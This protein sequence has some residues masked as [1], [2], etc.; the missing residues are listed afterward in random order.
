MKSLAQTRTLEERLRT[1]LA[2][3]RLRAEPFA[4]HHCD[5]VAAAYNLLASEV[6]T[7]LRAWDNE[8]VPIRDAAA[9]SGYSAEHLRRLAR[10][11]RI[12]SG[13]GPGARSQLR[14]RR[15]SLPAKTGARARTTHGRRKSRLEKGVPV[16]GT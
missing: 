2:S 12:L 14:V 1:L 4:A 15:D 7:E 6:E 11:G 9:E 5:A 16:F 8:T 3:W 10:G 13:R